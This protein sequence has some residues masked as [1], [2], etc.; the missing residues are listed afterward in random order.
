MALSSPLIPPPLTISLSTSPSLTVNYNVNDGTTTTANTATITITGAND[1]PI[2]AAITSTKTEDDDVYT[3]DLLSTATDTDGSNQL[4]VTGYSPSAIDH[5]SNAIDIPTGALTRNSHQ[6]TVDPSAFN[7]LAAGEQVQISVAYNVNDGTAEIP[8]T[9]TITITGANDGPVITTGVVSASPGEPDQHAALLASG[10]INVADPDLSD[11]VNA[12]ISGV[13]VSGSFIDSGASLPTPL[14]AGGNCRHLEHARLQPETS[15]LADA[16]DGSDITWSFES[17]SS[18]DQGFEF[19]AEGETLILTYQITLSDTSSD[20]SSETTTVEITITGSNDTPTIDFDPGENRGA[21][22]E[23]GDTISATGDMNVVDIDINDNVALGIAE[24]NINQGINTHLADSIYDLSA[25]GANPYVIDIDLGQNWS[26]EAEYR[27]DGNVGSDLNTLF[28]YGDYTDGILL[29][30]LRGDGFYLKGNNAGSPNLFADHS[31]DGNG[32]NTNNEFVPVRIT[33]AASN[34][35]GT[36]EVFVDDVL[37]F[38]HNRTD[39]GALNP[40]TK[41]IWIGS[42]HHRPVEGFDGAVRNITITSENI[43]QRPIATSVEVTGGSFDA[44]QLPTAL[45]DNDY[46]QLLEMLV[47]SAVE[48]IHAVSADPTAGSDFSWTFTSG[49]RAAS[50]PLISSPVV[51]RLSSPTASRQP[52][53]PPNGAVK[54]VIPTPQMW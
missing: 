31:N 38:T 29:R 13:T 26:F 50:L 4:T 44:S 9:A 19:L 28:S 42:A 10:S 54:T 15:H 52:T 53:A 43:T 45:S 16:P 12:A 24:N 14:S 22:T 40:S 8:N 32:T 36:L 3:L 1:A 17:A 25:N 2:V 35:G 37:N 7:H 41:Q 39:L 30:T 33:Y 27:M 34:S 23:T 6:L 11:Q 20:S 47:L 18:G 49:E 46:A 5:N 48:P 51:K 21:V